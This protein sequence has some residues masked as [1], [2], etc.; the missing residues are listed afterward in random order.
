MRL[1]PPASGLLLLAACAG[2]PEA[3]GEGAPMLLVSDRG[4]ALRIYEETGEGAARLAGSRDPGDRSWSDT[5]P[6]RLPDGRIVFVSDRDGNPE[7]YIA[8]ADGGA[9]RLTFDPLDR[10][11][12]DSGPAPLGRDRIVFARTEAGAVPGAPRD[13]FAMRLDGSGMTR[14]T[15][16]SADDGEPSA[17]GDGRSIVFVS[18]RTGTARIHLIPDAQAADPEAAAVCLSDFELPRSSAAPGGRASEDTAPAF[19]PDGSIVFGRTPA[20]G[21]PHLYVMGRSGARAGLRQITDSLTLPFGAAEP[22]VLDDRTILFVTGPIVDRERRHGPSRF[23]VYRIALGGFN[24]TRVTREQAPYG[25]FTRRL[26]AG[27]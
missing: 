21:Q 1:L 10:P 14:L 27:R 3:I 24:L 12:A 18:G 25:D 23:A 26:A 11:A 15:R 19:L 2:R 4:G 20:G 9:S 16:H 8:A 22:V 5:M 17:S 13:L 7:I 6:A